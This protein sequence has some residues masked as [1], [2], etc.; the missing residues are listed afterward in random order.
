MRDMISPPF[1]SVV[2][3]IDFSDCSANA[4]K[5]AAWLAQAASKPLRLLHAVHVDMPAY[6]TEQQRD[7]I[8]TQWAA[9]REHAEQHLREWSAPNLPVGL[10]VVYEVSDAPP[11][12][13]I[14][15][16][17]HRGNAWVVMGTHGR[18]GWRQVW[19][20]SVTTRTIEQAKVPV[21]AI[22]PDKSVC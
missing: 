11:V 20:G 4:L 16:A 8:L 1:E 13:A 6:L 5:W 10:D 22:P 15:A 18:T 9:V 3:P 17:A 7:G 2:C 12:E 19:M 21:L 14:I